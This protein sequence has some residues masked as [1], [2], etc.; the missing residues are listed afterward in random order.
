LTA[1]FSAL[2]ARLNAFRADLA[3]ARLEGRAEAGR[4]VAGR[5]A[6]ICVSV[7][8]VRKA[9]KPD[10]GVN[11]QF[12]CG[13][14]VLV[15]EESDGWA[16]V[17]AVRDSYVGYVEA[18]EIAGREGEPT[19]MVS[20]PRTFVYPGPDLRFPH[21]GALSLGSTVTVA[22]GA[23]T[24]GTHY[25]LLPS[26]E[27]VV[28]GHLR[29]LAEPAADYVAVAET[30]LGTPYLWGGA[31]G[32]GIDCSGLVQLALR[33]AGRDVPRDSDMQ[34]AGLGEA[35]EPGA[36]FSGVKRGDLVFWKGHVAIMT[37]D[38]EMIHASGHTMQVCRE[39]L[40]QAVDRIG[41]LYGGPTGFRR[42]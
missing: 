22:G 17:Q 5:P 15:F 36:D 13:D 31:S 30:L 11:T 1:H 10:A 6:R 35:F 8:D 23:E 27:A 38:T 3:D 7:A 19:H 41:Y 2:D 42:P 20:V 28:A 25:A 9:P 4:F 18:S 32:F 37:S 40:K 16:W 14:D 34:A 33:V 26:G 12:L 24:R 29:P 39:G 21:A